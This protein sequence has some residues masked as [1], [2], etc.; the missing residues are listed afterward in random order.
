VA[1]REVTGGTL[2]RGRPRFRIWARQRAVWLT[3]AVLAAATL[4]LVLLAIHVLVGWPPLTALLACF[5]PAVLGVAAADLS[6]L[7][8]HGVRV[9]G[10][11]V[12]AA[13]ATFASVGAVAA[14]ALGLGHPPVGDEGDWLAA[15]ILA[16]VA[17]T[18][19]FSPFRRWLEDCT[20][21]FAPQAVGATNV[22][23][24]LFER[25]QAQG[26]RLDDLLVELAESL[27]TSF[28]LRSVEWW[29]GGDGLYRRAVSVPPRPAEPLVLSRA[30]ETVLARMDFVGEEWL[31]V[32]L[33]GFAGAEGGCVVAPITHGVEL[34]GLLALDRGPVEAR[35][36]AVDS[37]IASVV[38][39]LCV[40]I[41][42]LLK[43][44]RLDTALRESLDELRSQASK[45]AAS[46][47]RV[48]QAADDERRRIE[49]NLHDGLQQH[50]V[51]ATLELRLARELSASDRPRADEIMAGL[52]RELE[53]ALE[54]L[55]AL[56]HGV[57][58]PALR[59]QGLKP[60]LAAAARRATRP[61]SVAVETNGRHA[62]EVEA[63]VYFC[64]LEAIQN[65]CKHAGSEAAVSVRVW[66]Q[67]GGVVFE[68]TDDGRGFSSREPHGVGLLN[69]EDRVGALGGTLTIDSVPGRGTTIRGMVA[70]SP[71]EV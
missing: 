44:A 55:R 14:I 13:A 45:L 1:A 26:V 66:E 70:A 63:T 29:S 57:Y 64:C 28:G 65:A 5:V 20:S 2:A 9:L 60:V 69:L 68:I 18:L 71:A 33:P 4:A 38:P 51:G 30:Q 37:K 3:A 67:G 21:R 12:W 17:A 22:P 40:R 11:S 6:S 36:A 54:E 47:A 52:E 16:A 23:A 8:P 41:G 25:R 10:A 19:C 62:P 46:R 27:C 48:V 7:R 49:R 53:H 61:T 24:D 59:D 31:S 43:N 34:V 50:L 56:A 42:P 58:P 15:S 32:W 39:E 35:D